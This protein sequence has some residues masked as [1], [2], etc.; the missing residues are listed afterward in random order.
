MDMACTRV[1]HTHTQA[2][3]HAHTH[4]HPHP[5]LTL[6]ASNWQLLKPTF[7]ECTTAKQALASA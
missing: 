2:H 6:T 3:S 5:P 4:P 7:R 1:R